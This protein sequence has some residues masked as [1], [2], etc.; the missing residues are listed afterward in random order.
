MFE[1]SMWACSQNDQSDRLTLQPLVRFLM[2]QFPPCSRPGMV[3][4]ASLAALSNWGVPFSRPP[5]RA[6]DGWG[7]LAASHHTT[8]VTVKADARSLGRCSG[9]LSHWNFQVL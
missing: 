4:A 8:G 3:L 1:V 7:R 9:K 2:S 5:R 6:P